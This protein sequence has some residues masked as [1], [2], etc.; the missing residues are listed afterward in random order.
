MN[1]TI[2]KP[3]YHGLKSNFCKIFKSLK[4]YHCDVNSSRVVASIIQTLLKEELQ[5][6]SVEETLILTEAIVL[7]FYSCLVSD[8]GTAYGISENHHDLNMRVTELYLCR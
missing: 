2:V 7:F 4:E 8:S 6:I 5:Q 1:N 3:V